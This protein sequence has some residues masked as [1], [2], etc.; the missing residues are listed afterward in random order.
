M[1][2]SSKDVFLLKLSEHTF[3][4]HYFF[5]WELLKA[6]LKSITFFPTVLTT[7]TALWAPNVLNRDICLTNCTSSFILQ[8]HNMNCTLVFM[9]LGESICMKCRKQWINLINLDTCLW[10]RPEVSHLLWKRLVSSLL[11]DRNWDRR[12]E[13]EVR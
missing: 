9:M 6:K 13:S 5:I 2:M 3:L 8:S 12:A 10:I 11:Q 7:I 4:S 1:F